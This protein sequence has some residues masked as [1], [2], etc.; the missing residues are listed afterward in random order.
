LSG[1]NPPSKKRGDFLS[2]PPRCVVFPPA[3]AQ[4][5]AARN[6]SEVVMSGPENPV[7]TNASDSRFFQV[8]GTAAADLW[9]K[10]PQDLQHALFER[11]VVLGHK[12]ERDESLREQLA[13]FLHDH[14]ARTAERA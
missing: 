12:G 5:D 10:L 9:S 1:W 6:L 11:A 13:K 14:H 8:L 7:A 4:S 2:R 3:L